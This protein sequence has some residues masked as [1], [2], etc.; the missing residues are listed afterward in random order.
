MS[1]TAFIDQ[2]RTFDTTEWD[3]ATNTAGPDG[4]TD[5]G[6]YQAYVTTGNMAGTNE[7]QI[8]CYE[9]AR[10]ADTQRLLFQQNLVGPQIG[11]WTHSPLLLTA[12][13]SFTAKAVVGSFACG[14]SI[15]QLAV[16]SELYSGTSAIGS[17]EWSLSTDSA[18]PDVDTTA[19]SYQLFLDLFDMV[20]ADELQITMYEKG[21]SAGSQAIS[22]RVPL[23]GK[24]PFPM[25]ASPAFM[26]MH[27][28]DFALKAISGT[29]TVPWS[30]RKAA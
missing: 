20:S 4:T 28:W 9:K 26:L 24:R 29:I 3:L 23:L 1:V 27:G 12:G 21:H 10:A 8:S 16:G 5:D 17:A 13:W 19:G 30:I 2:S 22:Y 14:W 18:G 11:L 25:W 7:L 15:R 6:V